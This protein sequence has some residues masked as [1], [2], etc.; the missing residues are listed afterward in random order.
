MN[1]YELQ[2]HLDVSHDHDISARLCIL[3]RNMSQEK[4]TEP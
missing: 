4:C 2:A 1:S 3:P